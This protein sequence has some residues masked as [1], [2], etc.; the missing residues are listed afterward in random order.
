MGEQLTL[1]TTKRDM[2][3]QIDTI[4]SMQHNN[5]IKQQQQRLMETNENIQSCL[6]NQISPQY[7]YKNNHHHNIKRRNLQKI[8]L[9][10]EELKNFV[11]E[12]NQ[13]ISNHKTDLNNFKLKRQSFHSQKFTA[14]KK[15]HFNP[16]R[17]SF[18]SF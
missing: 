2:M 9:E 17:M 11:N 16:L 13:N 1:L 14:I 4:K 18:P 8:N 12:C 7:E 15:G 3:Q 6:N 5:N 10:L